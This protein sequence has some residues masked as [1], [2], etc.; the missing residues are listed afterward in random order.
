MR[1]GIAG[2]GL[3]GSLL[4]WFL[5]ERGHHVD[6]FESSSEQA[7]QSAAY[8][9]ASM[10]AP[11]SERI[12]C[13]QKVWEHGVAS[14]KIWPGLL[15]KLGVPFGIDGSIVIAHGSDMKLLQKFESTL[16]NRFRIEG[17]QSLDRQGLVQLESGLGPQFQTGLYLPLE[18]WLDNR[19]LLRRLGEKAG[20]IHF[21]SSGRPLELVDQFDVVIDCR[22]TGAMEDEPELR[23]VR[24]DVVRV[25]ADE[26]SLS[27]PVRLMHPKYQ[28]YIAP[29]GDHEYVIGATQIESNSDTNPTVQSVLE[30]LS[31]AFTVHSGFAEAE[32]MEISKG[33]R[34]AY[35]DNDP[36]VYWRG[37]VLSVNGLYRHG[38]LIA[39]AVASEVVQ[40]IEETCSLRSTAI[41]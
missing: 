4:H 15:E 1:V 13:S 33:L 24:G 40:T 5:T 7:P 29:R 27:R 32:V 12:E 30:L 9:A 3:M 11:C 8:V 25:R 22:G 36:R 18:G 17:I 34:P 19:M 41:A 14:L 20:N 39:P 6:L 23:A 31:A 21:D 16:R 35:P 37:P 38:F 2:G 28:I 26:V 10:L